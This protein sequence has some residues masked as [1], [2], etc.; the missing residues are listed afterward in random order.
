[1]PGTA[2]LTVICL[3]WAKREAD[4][5]LYYILVKGEPL[6]LVLY[7]DDLFFT[8]SEKLIADCKRDLVVEFVMKELALMH[9]FLGL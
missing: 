1:V 2:G 8:R 5:N 9:Y 3:G 4:S 6:I 7:V